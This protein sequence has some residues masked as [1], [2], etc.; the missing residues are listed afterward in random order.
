AVLLVPGVTRTNTSTEAIIKGGRSAHN[1]YLIDGLDV[2][3]PVSHTA[4]QLLAFDSIDAVQVITSGFDAEYNVFGGVINTITREGSD[5]WHGSVSAYGTNA[6]LDNRKAEGLSSNERDRVF[7]ESPQ[8]PTYT[9][10]A[11]GTLGGP[12]IKHRLWFNATF[13]YRYAQ[14]G[15]L[16]GPPM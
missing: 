15:K 10:I 6:S 9:Y 3:D 7:D 2:T 16:V 4:Q 1:K 14:T 5:E 12:I 11:T 8:A 13:E